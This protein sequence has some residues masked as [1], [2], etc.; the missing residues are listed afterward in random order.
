MGTA[1][2]VDSLAPEM[3]V[4]VD[5]VFWHPLAS[6]SSTD[7]QVRPGIFPLADAVAAIQGAARRAAGAGKG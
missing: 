6:P 3:T 7:M 2:D 4:T 1:V 5:G